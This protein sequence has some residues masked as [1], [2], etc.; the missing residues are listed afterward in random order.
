V[1][2]L[3]EEGCTIPFLA[4]YRKE[5]TGG[6]DE[7]QL[8]DIQTARAQWEALEG[9][10]AGIL[11]SLQEQGV[12]DEALLGAIHAAEHLSTLEDLYLPYKPKRKTRAGRALE[13]GLEPLARMMC[14]QPNGPSPEDAAGR[15]VKGQVGSVREALA[16]A[17]DI[18]AEWSSETAEIRQ[19]VRDK[20]NR[21]GTLV[22]SLKKGAEDPRE[23]YRSYYDFR[24]A[25]SRLA[26]HQVLAIDRG[27]REKILKVDLEWNERDWKDP[28]WR[29]YRPRAQSS[30]GSLLAQAL[31]DGARR[32][33]LPA[34][35]R[36]V[37]RGLTEKAQAHAI[38]VFAGN[39]R[40][41]L[42]VPPLANHVVMALDPGFRTGCKLAVVD[43][44]GKLLQTATIYPHPPQKQWRESLAELGQM[45]TRHKVTLLAIG[46]GTASRESEQ[47]AAELVKQHSGLSYLMVSEAG[48]SVYSASPLARAELPGLDV[49]LRGAVSIARRVLD[50][51]AELIK[52]DPKSV[53]VGMYQHDLDE[54]KLDG[55]L[56]SVVESVVHNVG[57]ELNTASPALLSHVGGIGPRMSEKIVA[58]REKNGPFPSRAALT[59]IS[60][61]GPKAFEQAAGFLRIRDG[62]EP[63]DAT[64][65]HPESYAVARQVAKIAQGNPASLDLKTLS[66]QL[67][68][69]VPTLG[70]IVQQLQKPGRDPR[71]DLPAPVLRKDVLSLEDIYP[72]L[73]LPGTVRNVVDFGAF[74]D[75]GVKQDGLI[76]R[77]QLKGRRLS[78]GDVLD[79]EVL[80]IDPRRGRIGLGLA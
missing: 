33:L 38:D 72:G 7:E 6:L 75:L 64:A 32:L 9:R 37:R 22:V 47:L 10:R 21:F 60:G 45:V 76:H 58:Y 49:S 57:V 77:S 52:I 23:T 73:I 17:M 59:K 15:F 54:K 29:A 19:T 46:N 12:K 78:V 51:L 25:V 43:P 80:E 16:G 2:S 66:A 61:L 20:G 39:L 69:P 41:L 79:F 5:R 50:P 65:I 48:A 36:D 63:L 24:G 44:T 8:R 14:A 18:V 56:A 40:S 11:K 55:A 71:M 68:C 34:V 35:E 31:E 3:L 53:G 28:L 62:V 70:D 1:V 67:S 74:V 30:W 27:E 26:P 4:R 42:L 13:L